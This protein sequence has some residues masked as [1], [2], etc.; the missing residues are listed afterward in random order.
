[1]T[2]RQLARVQDPFSGAVMQACF[3]LSAADNTRRAY[4]ADYLAWRTFCAGTGLDPARGDDVAVAAWAETMKKDGLASRTR[5]RR[6]SA[7]SSIYDRLR[8][9]K[10]VENNPFSAQEG[11]KREPA[12]TA[13]PTPVAEAEAVAA[14][15]AACR[16][17]PEPW[18]WRN[19][20]ILRILW[21]TGLR[22]ASL[23]ELT[24]E[25]LQ[26]A[27]E[28]LPS[29]YRPAFY[30]ELPAKGGKE[31]KIYIRGAAAVALQR[32]LDAAEIKTGPIL[33]AQKGKGALSPRDI[34]RV[35]KSM[36]AKASVD[37]APHQFRVAFLT[38]NPASLESRQDAAA[39]ADPST[40]RKY[41]RHWRGR[42]AFEKMPEVEDL[43]KEKP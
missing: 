9:K 42:E 11:P 38:L 37:L 4:W 35:V 39:H 13:R 30:C 22:R 26:D 28:H 32:W 29:G 34:W 17:V 3:T 41:D 40:T 5:A 33:I 25:L 16:D 43:I 23:A 15:I 21:S 1:M 19:E 2:T 14:A 12:R 27:G 36:G 18:C 8:R 7:L 24:V 10:L 6:L 31:V 20:A